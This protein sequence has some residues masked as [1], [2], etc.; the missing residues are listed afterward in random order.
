MRPSAVVKI[1]GSLLRHPDE[2]KAL[3]LELGGLMSKKHL[4][5]VPGGGEFADIVRRIDVELNLKPEVSHLMALM[6]MNVY[7]LLLASLIPGARAIEELGEAEEG[8]AVI[9]P[10]REASRDP[11]LL[12]GWDVTGDAIAAR[13]AERLR[14]KL[15]VLV[16][17]VDGL[18]DSSGRL[19]EE[20]EASKLRGWSCVDP[21]AP[22]IIK[23]AKI[24]CLVV[25]GLFRERLVNALYGN[26][27][28]G[29]L[30]KP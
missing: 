28:L 11:G 30:I 1:G 10:Y 12:V 7:G 23:R 9:L 27:P 17:E 24:P 5:I 16:K 13:L 25:N 4:L 8:S 26:R 19:I 29:T 21:V 22:V 18:L 3:C 20:V 2:L 6:S 14:A 15:L